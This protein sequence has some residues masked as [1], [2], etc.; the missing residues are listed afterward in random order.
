MF[1][2]LPQKFA[3][4]VASAIGKWFH[5]RDQKSDFVPMFAKGM[6]NCSLQILL[7]GYTLEDTKDGRVYFTLSQSIFGFCKW[8]KLLNKK[9]TNTK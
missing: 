3:F 9:W 1:G 6:E 4:D 7:Q 8:S 5:E 2:G